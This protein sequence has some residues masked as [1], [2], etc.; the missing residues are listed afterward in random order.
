MH[1][2]F[3]YGLVGLIIGGLIF[4]V[5]I[6]FGLST[7]RERP[8]G[9]FGMLPIQNRRSF[10][11]R[12][13]ASGKNYQPEQPVLYTFSLVD[14]QG[15][16]AKDFVTVHEKI[17]HVIVV[18]KDLQD[19]QHV[20]PEFNQ[21]TG[22]FTL[23]N[24]SF[25]SDGPY[26]I[27]ADFT[28]MSAQRGPDG[29]PLTVTIHEDVNVGTLAN[30]KPQPL[31]ESNRTQEFEGYQVELETNPAL[32]T[33]Q[34]STTVSFTIRQNSKPVTDLEKYLGALGH[35][36]VLREGDLEFIHTHAL[37]DDVSR[38]NGTVDF[39]VVFPQPGKYKIFAQFQHQ[40]DVF[41]TS[42]VV[43]VEA[44]A[45]TNMMDMPAMDHN[46]HR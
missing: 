9:D 35:S 12:S 28:P 25:S 41:T 33:A 38:Q 29:Q 13:D 1:D 46:M 15:N 42:F 26:R 3:G 16:T 19:F 36:V 17:M 39:Q 5:V 45:G 31:V 32:I 27:F 43:S 37:R 34:A 30:Y 40:G 23:A 18:R 6:L 4:L 24:L 8:K 7:L 2:K 21:V 11:L 44:V 22:K 14:D 10:T 20:H